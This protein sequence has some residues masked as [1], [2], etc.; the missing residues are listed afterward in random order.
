MARAETLKVSGAEAASFSL[1]RILAQLDC[2]EAAGLKLPWN[3]SINCQGESIRRFQHAGMAKLGESLV[4]MAG[5]QLLARD[6][7]QIQI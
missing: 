3:A 6:D 5:E 4:E 1:S 7:Y 2:A